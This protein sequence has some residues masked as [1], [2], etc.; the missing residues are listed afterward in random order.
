MVPMGTN[1]RL[2]A[3]CIKANIAAFTVHVGFGPSAD[4]QVFGHHPNIATTTHATTM[5]I[6]MPICIQYRIGV[7]SL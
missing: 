7:A 1:G 5:L 4:A 3:R 6:R 2:G